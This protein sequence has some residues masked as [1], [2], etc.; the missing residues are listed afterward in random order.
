ML[1]A[2]GAAVRRFVERLQAVATD[3]I[4]AQSVS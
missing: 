3:V 2:A 1:L 4:A